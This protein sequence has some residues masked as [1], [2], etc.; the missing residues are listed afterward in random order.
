MNNN[1]IEVK[2]VEEANKIDMNLYTFME[3]FSSTR[4]SFV[5]KIRETKRI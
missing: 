5:F 3:R 2:S 4:G 1:F